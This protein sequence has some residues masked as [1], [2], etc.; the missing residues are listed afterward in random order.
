MQNTHIYPAFDAFDDGFLAVSDLHTIHFEQSGNIEGIPVIILHGGP[1]GGMRSEYRRYFDP[2]KWHIIQLSQR[3]CGK[4]TP[5]AELRENTT[6]NLVED[7]EKLRTHL[8]IEQ[9]AVFGG[10]W[11]STLSLAYSQ[12]HPDACLALFLRGIFLVRDREIKW[13]YQE[14]CSRIFPDAWE[15]FVEPIPAA[16]RDDF[17]SAY[18]KRLTDERPEVRQKAAKAWSTW[19]ASNLK[20][21]PDNDLI[22]SFGESNFAEAF[23]RIECH[24][25]INKCFFDEDNY[26]LNRIDR[27]RHLPCVIVQGR[28]D[29]VCPT[30]SAW[31]LH[32]AWPEATLHIVADAGHAVSE[33]GIQKELVAAT[34]AFTV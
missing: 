19:E 8:N 15:A 14:G 26:L 6:W 20:L 24:Y 25:F 30:E 31:D 11:G 1:G 29:I 7:I 23:A 4:S 27:I 12:S 18:Y 10:S 17:V 13:F 33:T 3:G 22:E 9:W 5:F 28:Y 2:Q 21:I 16:E 34:D 32:K